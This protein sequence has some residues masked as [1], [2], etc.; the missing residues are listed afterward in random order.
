MHTLTL[1]A[2]KC[3]LLSFDIIKPRQTLERQWVYLVKR[4]ENKNL[5][6]LKGL[7]VGLL[8]TTLLYLLFYFLTAVNDFIVFKGV[9]MVLIALGWCALPV[10]L[11]VTAISRVRSKQRLK[12]FLASI[13]DNQLSYSVQIDEVKV[14]ITSADHTYEIPWTEFS[15]YGIYRDT[16]YVFNTVKGIN[17]LYWDRTEMGPEAFSTLVDILKQKSIKQAF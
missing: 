3:M 12:Q 17:S 5:M 2:I 11:L 15:A 1:D 16:L 6:L 4:G 10:L 7:F 9:V 13:A 14:T 8:L